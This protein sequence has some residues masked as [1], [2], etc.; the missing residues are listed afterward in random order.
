MRL[1]DMTLGQLQEKLFALTVQMERMR[2]NGQEITNRRRDWDAEI[3]AAFEGL[4]GLQDE[5]AQ[6]RVEID[7]RARLVAE[8]AEAQ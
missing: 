6:V 4:D 2:M 1:A 5:A 7:A 3:R 8:G